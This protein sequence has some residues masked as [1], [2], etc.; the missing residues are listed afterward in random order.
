MSVKLTVN[1]RT[2]PG[3]ISSV[4]TERFNGV[5]AVSSDWCA[6][7]RRAVLLS[8]A[9]ILSIL[10][11][12]FAGLVGTAAADDD[13]TEINSCTE[14]NTPGTYHLGSD[15]EPAKPDDWESWDSC[16]AINSSG[17]TL[18]GMGH[19]IDGEPVFDDVGN[20]QGV[21]VRNETSYV[22]PGHDHPET[23]KSGVVVQNVTIEH[24]ER[25]VR[26]QGVESS[27]VRD[28]EFQNVS[29]EIDRSSV[30]LAN[31]QSIDVTNITAK[32]GVRNRIVS[33]DN[34]TG[35]TISGANI[36]RDWDE[37]SAII[38]NGSSG[39]EIS[40]NRIYEPDVDS[41]R[42]R[43][44]QFGIEV[45]ESS[46][47]TV[48][49][50]TIVGV[51]DTSIAIGEYT[52]IPRP[53]NTDTTIADNTITDT[54]TGIL[55]SNSVGDTV[56]N[57][58]VSEVGVGIDVRDSTN[59]VV[60]EN[61]VTDVSTAGIR[62]K[63]GST[64][65]AIED[66]DI[67]EVGITSHGIHI[68]DSEPTSILDNSIEDDRRALYFEGDEID[69]DYEEFEITDRAV[70]GGTIHVDSYA[71]VS[72]RDV[73]TDEGDIVLEN[74]RNATV[75]ETTITDG[76]LVVDSRFVDE[77]DGVT[78]SGVDVIGFQEDDEHH[79]DIEEEASVFVTDADGSTFED[80]RSIDGNDTAFYVEDS[81]D[82]D[83]RNL[84]VTGHSTDRGG[85]IELVRLH[86]VDNASVNGLNVSD[87]PADPADLDHGHF[88][89]DGGV[90]A[91][92]LRLVDDTV[93]SDVDIQKNNHGAW[94]AID[95]SSGMSPTTNVTLED[96]RIGETV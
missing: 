26:F 72:I 39:I 94:P 34:I 66:N 56:E 17:V 88:V 83:L 74:A 36:E 42:D 43:D 59:N 58:I 73:D 52:T 30:D 7:P 50:N 22:V 78:V 44:V 3:P 18:D 80:V 28:V 67:D 11:I 5:N 21:V 13:A 37:N 70:D 6:G 95:V 62:T 35:G 55:L 75:S 86:L 10:V 14:I 51:A 71:H 60:V 64:G 87:N 65:T 38:V 45:L 25:P 84:T 69:I 53:G 57:N 4:T 9:V 19:S 8:A 15:I 76:Q 79:T 47:M 68:D 1:R 33:A 24:W 91:L 2:N 54:P 46:S 29:G 77:T 81:S 40:D 27:A 48:S 89:E 16:I 23:W 20:T 41:E 90:S 92:R 82:V 61:A 63:D 12:A 93:V 31:G 32:E 85:Q 49:E 96:A